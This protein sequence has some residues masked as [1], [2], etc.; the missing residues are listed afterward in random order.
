M[1]TT[2]RATTVAVMMLASAGIAKA[3]PNAAYSASSTGANTS[4]VVK[5]IDLVGLTPN[6]IYQFA[7][8]FWYNATGGPDWSGGQVGFTLGTTQYWSDV[9]TTNNTN[10]ASAASVM[11]SG[12]PVMQVVTDALGNAVVVIAATV[13]P[14]NIDDSKFKAGA[15]R[16]IEFGPVTVSNGVPN[17]T[18]VPG[19]IAGAGLPILLGF[20]GYAAWR[21][22]KARVSA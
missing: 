3:D 21:R 12:T 16:T 20:A 8:N 2:L 22:R 7:F 4:T 11:P 15:G 6:Y 13:F 10:N 9:I 18:V 19:P 17:P 1:Q 14:R 5:S